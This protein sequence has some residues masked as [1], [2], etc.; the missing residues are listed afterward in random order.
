MISV[1]KSE[2]RKKATRSFGALSKKSVASNEKR[3]KWRK[4]SDMSASSKVNN[5]KHEITSIWTKNLE[6]NMMK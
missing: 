6:E 2:T 5:Q 3:H 4:T 1:I